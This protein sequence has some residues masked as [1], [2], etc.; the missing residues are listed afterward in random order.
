MLKIRIEPL[1]E[2]GFLATSND[3][4][5]LLAEGDTVQETIENAIAI[6]KDLIEVSNKYG[7]PIAA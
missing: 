3:I 2:G 5:G 7:W 4:Q 1:E 6:A